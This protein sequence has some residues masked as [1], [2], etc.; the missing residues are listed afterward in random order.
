[1]IHSSLAMYGCPTLLA[2][3]NVLL[4]DGG[5][6]LGIPLQNLQH[7]FLDSH[8]EIGNAKSSLSSKWAPGQI[9]QKR[10]CTVY[11]ELYCCT[12]C[13]VLTY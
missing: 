5:V 9:V 1:M 8:S 7:G 11:T 12:V 6:Q 3:W 2:V 10:Y 13:Y 4:C